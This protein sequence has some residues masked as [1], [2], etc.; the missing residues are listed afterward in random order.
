MALSN[1]IRRED[2][3]HALKD[4]STV[5]VTVTYVII[6]PSVSTRAL[7]LLFVRLFLFL[8]T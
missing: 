4:L 5:A 6:A 1:K 7:I 2:M 8:L 3:A